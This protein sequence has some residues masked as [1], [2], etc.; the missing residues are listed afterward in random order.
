MDQP[1]EKRMLETTKQIE[2]LFDELFPIPRSITGEGYRKSLEILSRYVPF[3][4]HKTTSGEQ[5]FDWTVPDEWVIDD[6][7]LQEQQPRCR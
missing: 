7:F 6:A 3:E 4:I 5:V 1:C 2:A